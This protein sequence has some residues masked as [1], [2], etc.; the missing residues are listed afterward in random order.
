MKKLNLKQTALLVID[1]QNDFV[2]KNSF[3]NVPGIASN[4][5]R[6]K[7]FIDQCRAAGLPVIYTRHVFSL[8]RNPVEAKLFPQMGRRGLRRGTPGW[9]ITPVLKPV[10]GDLVIDKSRYDAFYKTSLE[11]IL[12]TKKISN[13]VITG[14]LTNVCCESTA[15]SAMNR[16]FWV[17]FLSDL[18]FTYTKKEQNNT[19]ENIAQHFGWIGSSDIFFTYIKNSLF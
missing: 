5:P 9:Q 1:M 15:R 4:L 19:L 12:K 17:W 11:K 8:K 10:S 14:T 18:T 6:F 2:V 13:V 3:L 16:D 7:K